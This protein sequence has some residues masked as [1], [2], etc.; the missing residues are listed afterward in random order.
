MSEFITLTEKISEF[1][2]KPRLYSSV[3]GIVFGNLGLAIATSTNHLDDFPNR[4]NEQKG[5]SNRTYDA[6]IQW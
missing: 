1:I 2:T 6:E 4:T 5:E 3:S